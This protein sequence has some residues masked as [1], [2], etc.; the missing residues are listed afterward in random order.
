M[1]AGIL[2]RVNARDASWS[3]SRADIEEMAKN[4]H[5]AVTRIL[6]DVRAGGAEAVR[7]LGERFG[8]LA[9]GD[10]LLATRD[11]LE[12]ASA[13]CDTELLDALERVAGRVRAFASAQRAALSDVEIPI[14]GGRAGH[15]VSAVETAGCYVPGGRFPL[16]SSAIMTA[17]T[18]RVAGV[19]SV[20]VASPRPTTATLA[21]AAIADADGVLRVGGAHA[22]AAMAFGVAGIPRCDVVCGPGNRF[23]TEAKRSLYGTL[24]VDLVAGPSEL[25]IVADA[26]TDPALAA[27]DLVA[28]AEHDVDARVAL[29]ATA[30]EIIDAIDAAIA[31]RV[32]TLSTAEVA[33]A[34][35]RAA[36]AI[37]VRDLDEAVAVADRLAPEHLQVMTRDARA[38]ARRFRHYG[39]IFVG[40]ATGTVVGDYGAGPNHTLPTGGAAR[41]SGGL[42][43]SS[44]LRTRTWVE[45]DDP[46]AARGIYEDAARVARA[47]GLEGHALSA[48]Y[49]LASRGVPLPESAGQD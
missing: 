42:S 9:P 36:T 2:R 18:A 7:R 5:R 10:P 22:I 25:A 44:F 3:A 29:I 37:P 30:P 15:A 41:F 23:V 45:L 13:A 20:W 46:S 26:T 47:E 24:G 38:L 27:A 21:A 33:R 35:L 12:R 6:D 39:A 1:S 19:G 28:Q 17:V 4:T 8:D 16:P 40:S 43:V 31:N 49:R 14:P 48:E 11:D 32:D 34:S